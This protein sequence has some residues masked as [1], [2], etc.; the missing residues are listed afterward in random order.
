MVLQHGL[1][2]VGSR[3]ATPGTGRKNPEPEPTGRT[4]LAEPSGRT[5][6]QNPPTLY[7]ILD[8]DLARARGHDPLDLASIFF[9]AG[10]R[11]LQIRAKH[12]DSGP[13]LRLSRGVVA[14]GRPREATVVINDRADI[15]VLAGADGVHVGQDDLSPEAVRRIMPA[16]ILGLS[17][18]SRVQFEAALLTPATYIA[19]GPVFGTATKDTGYAAVGLEFVRW[20]AGRSDRPVVGI[21]G[22]TAEN[23]GQVLEAG[24]TS[25]AVIGDLLAGDP[26]ERVRRYFPV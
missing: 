7:A 12:L 5:G 17:T 2:S 6:R 13:L 19:V 15:G 25:V 23:A 4:K 24:A 18:H 21:G 10:V 26:A 14:A 9:T 16:G 8:V 1:G 22:I 20:A 11:F 3:A